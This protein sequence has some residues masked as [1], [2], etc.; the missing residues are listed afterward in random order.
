MYGIL[1]SWGPVAEPPALC[2]TFGAAASELSGARRL[3]H[4][5]GGPRTVYLFPR[6][7]PHLPR[8]GWR[9]Q[10]RRWDE[11][12]RSYLRRSA[13]TCESD[14][15]LAN[16]SAGQ[17]AGRLWPLGRMCFPPSATTT[18]VEAPATSSLHLGGGAACALQDMRHCRQRLPGARRLRHW[19]GG[20]QAILLLPRELVS[21]QPRCVLIAPHFHTQLGGG[22][23]CALQDIRHRRQQTARSPPPATLGWR[24]PGDPPSPS[25]GSSTSARL[26][27]ATTAVAATAAELPALQRRHCEAAAVSFSRQSALD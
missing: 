13:A 19:D 4:W 2:R 23:A 7:G 12:Q 20:P 22:A 18:G 14:G 24:A 21:Q 15:H 17:P 3:R 11:R 6:R 10:Q 5:G 16:L 8:R 9:R 26:E 25:A 1:S 27:V